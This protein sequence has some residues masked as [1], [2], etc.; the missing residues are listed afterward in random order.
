[1]IV[2]I[3]FDI[4]SIDRIKKAIDSH[5]ERFLNRV[6]TETENEYCSSRANPYESYAARF[7]VKEAAFKA[8]GKGWNECGGFWNVEV[9][10]KGGKP[11]VVFYGVVKDLADKEKITR[12]HTTIT[13]DRGISA[14]V[15]VLERA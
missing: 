3:G 13:H 9:T 1:M 2:G 7:A 15:V 12:I 10:S 4:V 8:I 14:A 5:G 11:N 6:F